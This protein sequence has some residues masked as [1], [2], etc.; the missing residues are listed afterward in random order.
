[1]D[2]LYKNLRVMIFL[3]FSHYSEKPWQ[4]QKYFSF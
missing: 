4:Y 3:Y 2:F 1:M